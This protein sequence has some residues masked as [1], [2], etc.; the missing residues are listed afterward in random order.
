MSP[1][2]T[3]KRGSSLGS[4]SASVD[5]PRTGRAILK[6]VPRVVISRLARNSLS[7]CMAATHNSSAVDLGNAY[8]IQDDK[9]ISSLHGF[10]VHMRSFS[11]RNM[12]WNLARGIERPVVNSSASCL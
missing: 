9:C 6:R 12:K 1:S 4:K 7:Q 8:T 2:R 11:S 3:G 5:T 10:R